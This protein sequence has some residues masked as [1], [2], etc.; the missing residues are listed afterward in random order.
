MVVLPPLECSFQFMII[1]LISLMTTN[2]WRMISCGKSV[3]IFR[4]GTK[5]INSRELIIYILPVAQVSK[6]VGDD[7]Q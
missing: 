6:K 1:L 4:C 2:F 5:I 3:M 7:L